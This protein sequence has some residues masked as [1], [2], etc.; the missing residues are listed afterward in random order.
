M[1][2]ARE[3][4]LTQ[5]FMT[6]QTLVLLFIGGMIF[7][8]AG[9]ELL[10]RGAS[11]LAVAVG[12]TPL[13]VGMTVV[14]YGTSAPEVA[15]TVQAMY[16]PAAATGSGHRQ[17]RGQQYLQRAAGAGTGL[18]G[19]SPAGVP[20]ARPRHRSVHDCGHGS[21]LVDEPRRCHRS[22]R[23]AWHCWSAPCCF[24]LSRSR[25]AAAPRLPHWPR[26]ARA[27]RPVPRS[28]NESPARP[29]T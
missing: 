17:Y 16:D 19:S 11:R 7:L 23:K 14:A 22:A 1:R 5:D 13:V 24:R 27:V 15:V 26:A 28:P 12:I 10:V 9:A 8:I 6:T 29:S 2:L 25:A 20:H 3:P 4:R 21:G 18:A